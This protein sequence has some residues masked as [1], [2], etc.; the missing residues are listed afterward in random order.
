[1]VTTERVRLPEKW[2]NPALLRW[3]RVQIGLT[4]ED[5]KAR[6]KI[7]AERVAAWEGGKEAPT[8]ADLEVLADL[9]VCP[10]GYFFLDSPPDVRLPLD[11]RGLAPEKVDKLS[12]ATRLHLREFVRLT[13][14]AGFLVETLG[15]SWEVRMGL[16]DLEEPVEL[17]ARR[18]RARL[19]FSPEMREQWASADDAFGFWQAAI[20][21]AGV[22]VIA[23]K[24]NP[25]EVRG[26]SEWVGSRP[27]A[28]LVNSDDMEAA[29][30]R[31]FTLLHEWAHL[32]VRDPGIVCDFRGH[33]SGGR[34][35]HFTNRL[36][37]EMM[38][39]RDEFEDLLRTQGLFQRR[40]NW[41]DAVLEK[42][43]QPFKMS[44]DVVS[45][46]LEEMGLARHGFYQAKR[47]IW[48]KRRAFF[49]RGR[50]P[51]RRRLT[52]VEYRLREVGIPL[53][54][55]VAAGY[56]RGAISKLDLADLLD[57]R[58]EQAERFVEWVQGEPEP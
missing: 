50:R 46:L 52:K 34:V 32:L 3:A 8:L 36:A 10:V 25:Q 53:G 37:A 15:L 49:A 58:V 35:E 40:D 27:P 6:A 57:L 43:R 42:I 28:I 21:K 38:V 48:E 39:S 1:M 16:A 51:T 2:A 23:L 5:V 9:Y 45:I 47:A 30:G 12:Y 7:P 56:E 33:E 17:V 13:E 20:E 41:G 31:T 26:A 54:R 24:L 19:G 29:T 18:E 44:R 22:F 14:Y 4:P 55:L 11:F